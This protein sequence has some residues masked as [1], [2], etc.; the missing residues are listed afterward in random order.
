MKRLCLLLV[1]LLCCGLF[2]LPVSA[3]SSAEFIEIEANVDPNGT[4]LVEMTVDVTFDSGVDDPKFPIP[5]D[6]TEISLNGGPANTSTR[7]Q[8]TWISLK[9]VG[10]GT[11][12]LRYRLPAVIATAEKKGPMMLNMPLLSGFS[13]PIDDLQIKI[14]FPNEVTGEPDFVSGYYQSNTMAI[15]QTH[16]EGNV[17]YGSAQD[18]M[19]HESLSLTMEVD[20]KM[21]PNAANRARVLGLMDLAVALAVVLA[22]VYYLAFMRPKL[23]KHRVWVT[24]PDGVT[25]GNTPLWLRG[26]KVDFSMMVVTWA[27]LGYLRIQVDDS[28]RILLHKRMEMGN[29]RSG[30]ECKCFRNLFG[31]R[32]V[33]D[34]T[35]YHYAQLCR[36]VNKKRPQFREV[37]RKSFGN[38]YVFWVLCMLPGVLGG[39]LIATGFAAHS[40]FLR[41]FMGLLMAVLSALIHH[42]GARL[43]ERNKLTLYIGLGASALWLLLGILSGKWL[44]AVMLTL[45][46]TLAGFA[47]SLGGKR[48]EPG[49]HAFEQLLGLRRYMCTVSKAE[50]QLVLKQNPSYFHDM[51]PY[52]LAMN[53][54]EMF[55]RRYGRLRLP[56]CTWLVSG[57]R[58]QISAVEWAKLLRA[59]VNTLDHRAKRLPLERLISK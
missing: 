15:L 46:Q 47:G 31:R 54:D 24:A 4:C 37:Y 35:G 36:I 39:I 8:I 32:R 55:A 14:T 1:L 34:G 22:A 5:A 17:I 21:F 42:M 58:G 30:F 50:L 6:A 3:R 49:Q 53:A 25:P 59:A 7:G 11:F 10:D 13:Y 57:V 9:R 27:Q 12:H 2:A 51:V 26:G 19:D 20:E 56:E 48:T 28:G 29:E 41:I 38:P 45:L 43:W 18:L 52:A 44:S 33:V 40:I 23:P 16:V